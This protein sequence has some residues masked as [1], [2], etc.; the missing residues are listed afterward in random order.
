MSVVEFQYNCSITIVQCN[1]NEKLGEIINN[2][3]SKA[4]VQKK[5]IYF[6]Y[7]GK[8]GVEFNEELTFS[9]MANTDDKQRKKM[10]V[11]VNN[12]NEKKNENKFIKPKNVICPICGEKSK[13]NINN[14]K[15]NLFDCK[16]DHKLSNLS[17]NEYEKKQKIDL[18]QIICG[19]CKMNNKSDTTNN[20]FYK[21]LECNL[22]LCPLCKSSH[23]INHNKNIIN[24]DDKDYK[25]GKHNEIFSK[26]CNNCKINICALCENE[27]LAHDSIYLTQLFHNKEEYQS[28]L[29]ELRK[30]I[31]IYNNE[32]N[33][34]IE[35][36]NGSKKYFEKFYEIEKDLINNYNIS[37]RNY[38]LLYNLN[39]ITKYNEQ[40]IKVI[41]EIYNE[42]NITNKFNNIFK[43]YN[44]ANNEIRLT[45]KIE[46]EDVNKDIYFLDNTDGLID[47]NKKE[48]EH[49]HDLL[50]ELNE[51]NVELY[52]NGKKYN[53]QKY[54]KP[55]KEGIY[56]VI[57]KINKR[58]KNCCGM[59]WSC[60][61]II[62]ID[63]S[64]FNTKNVTNMHAIFASCKNLKNI[65][66]SSFNTK[67]VI[68]MDYM[69]TGCKNLTNI[70]LS[71]F[72]IENLIDMNDMFINCNKLKQIKINKN[73]YK[74]IKNKKEN[75]DVFKN[76]N[77]IYV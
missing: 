53:Y 33:I 19:Q 73:S 58:I 42:N 66:L 35:I 71:T 31:D 8:S 43:I 63:L 52:I 4:K 22:N 57:L 2:F 37:N 20:V 48:E 45:L 30:S 51:S 64:S 77:I 21:C 59:F 3:I 17:F 12:I 32:I 55:E 23:N 39:E 75:E 38:E 47:I 56:L 27:H 13:L 28:K 25:C 49:H 54:F 62:N 26:Y 18:S 67:N 76:I 14:Y 1:E 44:K 69:F 36:L 50:K 61:N 60:K 6:S 7:N 46:K 10:S 5:D 29:N 24:Y 40:I 72:E 34:L 9:Q 41:N 11:L 70:D 74:K 15:I 65:N 16:N 68:S